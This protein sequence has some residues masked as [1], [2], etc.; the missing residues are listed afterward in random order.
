MDL[1]F[2]AF[3]TYLVLF[4]LMSETVNFTFLGHGY[5]CFLIIILG[6]CSG[7]QLTSLEIDRSFRVLHF[8]DFLGRPGAAFGFSHS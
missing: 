4:E 5:F 2:L 6:V 7:M 1:Y 8:E 3:F